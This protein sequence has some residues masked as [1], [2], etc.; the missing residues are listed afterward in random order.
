MMKKFWSAVLSSAVLFSTVLSPLVSYAESGDAVG[1]IYAT[2]IKACINGV[3]VDSYNIGGKTVVV[4]EDI[5]SQY[6]YSD[7][8]RT[9]VIDELSPEYLV[10]GSSHNATGAKPGTVV[11]NIYDTDIKTYFRG[12]ELTSYSLNGKM[13]VVIEELGVDSKVNFSEIGGRYTWDAENRTL[14]LESVYKYPY[15]LRYILSEKRLNMNIK[16]ERG[17]LWA[18]FVNNFNNYGHIVHEVKKNDNSMYEVLYNDGVNGTENIGYLCRFAEMKFENGQIVTKQTDADYF[19]MEKLSDILSDFEAVPMTYED[20][21]NHYEYQGY[22]IIDEFET[23][24]YHFLYMGFGLPHGGTQW[25]EKVSKKDGTVID[26][27]GQFESV[28]L[29][30]GKR[31]EN[32]SIDEENE[33][34]YLHYDSDYVIDL[35]TDEVTAYTVLTTDIGSG[36]TDGKPSEHDEQSARDSQKKY[37]LISADGELTVNGF[38]CHEYFYA[39][40]LP[41]KE[42]FDFYNIKYSFENDVLTIDTS[43]MKKKFAFDMSD[44]KSDFM[45]GEPIEY[46]YVDK[47]LLNGVKTDITYRYTSGHFEQM[48]TEMKK[49]K[50][51]IVNGKVYINDSFISLL[52]NE[53]SK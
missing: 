36:K 11:G 24:E 12:K 19:Y 37:K 23:D 51:Y 4:V 26:Y 32:V 48:R 41:L 17:L 15:A 20:R 34:V 13:A 22:R 30:G 3:W 52:F 28:S 50:P 47:V 46:M 7:A 39:T 38:F 42:T 25:L 43:D 1:K 53:E 49:A 44:E 21:M 29:G 33:K 16:D 8:L 5:T 40:M 45:N 14:S 6:K 10:E 31:F 35:K 18:E 27:S 2:D 9:L